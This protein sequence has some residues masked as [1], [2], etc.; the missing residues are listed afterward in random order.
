MVIFWIRNLR[1]MKFSYFCNIEIRILPSTLLVLRGMFFYLLSIMSKYDEQKKEYQQKHPGFEDNTKHIQK[2]VVFNELI[3]QLVK[4]KEETEGQREEDVLKDL[5]F[6]PLMKCLYFVCL[7][8]IHKTSQK[9]NTLFNLFDFTAYPKGWVD[10]ECYYSINDLEDYYIETDVAGKEYIAKREQKKLYYDGDNFDF[11]IGNLA[12]YIKDL[13][14][15]IKDLTDALFFPSFRNREGLVEL[16]HDELWEK[17]Y[18]SESDGNGK[19]ETDNWNKVYEIA[20]N[21]R[22]SVAA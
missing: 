9:E 4:W 15:A 13:K 1:F 17:A 6:V 22:Q 16:S 3:K 21:F 19:M 18:Y 10:E 11:F 5:S 20:K 12:F 8:S 7:L 2:L 14:S